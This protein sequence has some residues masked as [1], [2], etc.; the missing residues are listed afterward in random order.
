MG[1][2]GTPINHDGIVDDVIVLEDVI[3]LLGEGE[4]EAAHHIIRGLV[5]EKKKEV[6][7]RRR[8]TE[9]S[10]ANLKVLQKE[11]E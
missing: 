5:E 2:I 8:A 3:T 11:V 9:T 1:S 10:L 6:R 7:A 4:F